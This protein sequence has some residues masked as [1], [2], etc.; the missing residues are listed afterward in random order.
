MISGWAEGRGKLR[1]MTISYQ[2]QTFNT[3]NPIARYAHRSRLRRSLAHAMSLLPDRGQVLD[4]G[5]GTGDFLNAVRQKRPDAE[6]VGFDPYLRGHVEWFRRIGNMADIPD[7]SVDLLTCF[8]VL[9]HLSDEDVDGF[10]AQAHRVLK[11]NGRI[12]VSVPIIGGLTL[13]LKESNRVLLFRRRSDYSLFELLN[14]T[15]FGIPAPRPENRGP[16][17]KGFDF[18]A[19]QH[20]LASTFSMDLAEWCPFTTF[21]WWVNS[22]AFFVL[23]TK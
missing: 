21:P 15:F 7:A 3:P 18:R 4:F 22:Q 6:L 20:T 12:L 17:H 16:T 1:A 23:R 11:P 9:E 13:L 19:M 5:C 8:E 10:I 2:D 14:A